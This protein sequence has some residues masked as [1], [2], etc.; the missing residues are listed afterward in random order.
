MKDMPEQSV[1]FVL[2][3]I[4]YAAVNKRLK[5][6]NPFREKKGWSKRGKADEATFSLEQFL[7][8]VSKTTK[9]SIVIFCGIE[10][11]GQIYT[12]FRDTLEWPTRQLVWAKTNPPVVNGDK[13]YLSGTENAVWAK[14][15][16]APFKA[17]CKT[18]V[19][20]HPIGGGVW[21]DYTPDGKE[22]RAFKRVD[23][24]QHRA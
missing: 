23:F 19:F 21:R 11:L 17:K 8:L 2:T 1:D 20:R 3:D 22:P 5:E 24:G 6:V 9:K 15:P 16:G 10:Q 13:M 7:S 12:Y 4:P 14:R 18:N